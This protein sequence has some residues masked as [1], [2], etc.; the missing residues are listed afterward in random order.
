MS[1]LKKFWYVPAFA[2]LTIIGCIYVL[3]VGDRYT[4]CFDI[5]KNLSG[6]D[7]KVY[8]EEDSSGSVTISEHTRKDGHVYVKV[9]SGQQGKVYLCCDYEDIS[10]IKV[11]YVHPTGVITCDDYFGECTGCR[12]VQGVFAAYFLLLIIYMIVK[13]R[14]SHKE[15][16]YRYRNILYIGLI[17]FLVFFLYSQTAAAIGGGGL[18]SSLHMAM[19][20][21]ALLV[22]ITFPIVLAVSVMVII[23]NVNL[24][25]R[26]GFG[27]RNML[28]TMLVLALGFGSLVPFF[29]SMFLQNQRWLDVHNWTGIGRFVELFTT[30]TLYSF[31]AYLECV[32]FGTVI[33]GIHAAKHIPA[34]DKDYIIIHGCRIREDGT[35]TKLL[36]G[37]ADRAIWFAKQQKEKTGKDIVYVP[38]GGQGSDEIIS[39][40]EAIRRYLKDQ[41]IPE[42]QILIEDRSLTTEENMK[43]AMALIDERGGGN[44]AFATTNYH[45][46]RAGLLSSELGYRLDGIGGKTKSY[47]WINAFVR[48]FI[49]TIVKEKKRHAVVLCGLVL[50]N[51]LTC[52]LMY[53]SNVVLS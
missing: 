3:C 46:L 22:T 4:V 13:F 26:E 49:A 5:P 23:S 15:N 7:C 1:L 48:E 33:L 24:M 21:M 16:R 47:F 2:V 31:V 19:N 44:V 30:N 35:L 29:V 27:W 20:V 12:A 45:V 43:N 53:I 8:A 25:R 36:Q 34:F 40:A 38:S 17:L 51:L 32:L 6:T 9:S 18:V 37:R 10:S 42:E 11:L 28:A 50:L 14:R 41:G 39:E 52:V